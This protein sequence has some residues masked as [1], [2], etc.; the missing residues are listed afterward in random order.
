LKGEQHNYKEKIQ[1]LLFKCKVL[2][3]EELPEREG[4]GPAVMVDAWSQGTKVLTMWAPGEVAE[5][6][7]ELDDTTPVV[8]E[9]RTKPLELFDAPRENAKRVKA[10]RLQVLRVHRAGDA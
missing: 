7:A 4:F 8:L 5:E 10:L 2:G 3:L 1:M 6:L 9:L